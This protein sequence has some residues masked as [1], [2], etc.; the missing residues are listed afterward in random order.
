MRRLARWFLTGMGIGIAAGLLLFLGGSL[1]W[2][3]NPPEPVS[4]NPAA[5]VTAP[6][7]SVALAQ[8]TAMNDQVTISRHNGITRA[9]SIASSAVVGITVTQVR[10]YRAYNPMFDDPFFRHFFGVPEQRIRQKVESL[11][12]G[13]FISADGYVVTNEHVVHD[14]IEIIVTTTTGEQ[15]EADLIGT[16]FDSDLA[17]LKV[18]GKNLP[19]LKI[20]EDD[21]VIVGEWVIAIGNPFGL[22]N[23][24]DQPSASVGV[25]SATN[26]DFER[27]EAGRLYQDMIQTDAAINQ[28]NSGGPLVDILGEVIGVNTFIFS[29]S[30]GSVGIGFAIPAKRVRDV[31]DELKMR[32]GIDRDYWTGLAV[33]NL[34]RLIAM[35]LGYNKTEGVIVTDVERGSPAAKAGMKPTDIIFEIEGTPIP[36]AQSI[37]SYFNNHDLR[38][39]DTVR[40]KLFRGGKVRDFKLKLEARPK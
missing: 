38:V 20:A 1:T 18:K 12:S 8:R 14:A 21:D 17:L 10:E 39:G 36:D 26:R 19:F 33:Q 34:D 23:I 29:Q 11:G 40:G 27:N 28:G 35:S 32:G 37:R 22:F 30:G 9:V 24:N 31:I 2:K 13:F 5:G 4:A 16:D 7:G 25:V 3:R 6:A 15:Y